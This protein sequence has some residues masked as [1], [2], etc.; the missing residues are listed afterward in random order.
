MPQFKLE[1]IDKNLKEKMDLYNIYPQGVDVTAED[2]TG[3][4]IRANEDCFFLKAEDATL[5]SLRK[6]I[7]DMKEVAFRTQLID[8]WSNEGL[9]SCIEIK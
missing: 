4:R 1:I 9:T 3:A 5:R 2:E 8:I 6:E 7:K